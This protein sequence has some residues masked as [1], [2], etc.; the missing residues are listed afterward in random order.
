MILGTMKHPL[1]V[2]T[3]EKVGMVSLRSD[4]AEQGFRIFGLEESDSHK[5]HPREHGSHFR[6]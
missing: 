4:F 1:F 5:C 2:D 3:V 6:A